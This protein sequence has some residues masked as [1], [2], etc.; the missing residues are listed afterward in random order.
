MRTQVQSLALLSGLRIPHS[1]KLQHR[2]QMGLGY[3]VAMAVAQAAAATPIQPLAQELPY[4]AGAA[5]KKK[6]TIY[7][8]II[9]CQI[10][11]FQMY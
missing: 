6:K 4:A 5:I 8:E 7:L 9:S 2:S 1:Q 11:P 10:Q 3:S